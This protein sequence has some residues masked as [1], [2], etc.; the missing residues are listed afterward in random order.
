MSQTRTVKA[1]T[2]RLIILQLK[3]N[4]PK[5]VDI[6][7]ESAGS[8]RNYKI[9]RFVEK[10]VQRFYIKQFFKLKTYFFSNFAVHFFGYFKSNYLIKFLL[11]QHSL[12]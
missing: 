8:L 10:I 9:L 1:Y 7:N 11:A 2:Y 4:F 5:F 3:K 6:E 12:C